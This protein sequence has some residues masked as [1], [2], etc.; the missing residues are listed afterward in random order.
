MEPHK[1][2]V[3]FLLKNNRIEDFPFGKQQFQSQ[4][5]YMLFYFLKKE[6]F[7]KLE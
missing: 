2:G 6:S 7:F 1:A 5:W 3:A 4:N